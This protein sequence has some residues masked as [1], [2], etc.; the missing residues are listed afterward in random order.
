MAG[1]CDGIDRVATIVRAM[2]DFAHP[3]S[4]K[5][6]KVDLNGGMRS[7]LVVATNEYRYIADVET[8]LQDL[9]LVRCTAGD[10]NQLFLNLIVERHAGTLTF[11]SEVGQGRTFRVRLP[12]AG[13]PGLDAPESL[14]A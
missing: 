13:Q 1:S 10:L 7:T 8:D 9:P 5:Q 6:A 2:R 11:E 3:P 4:T 14:A 12:V